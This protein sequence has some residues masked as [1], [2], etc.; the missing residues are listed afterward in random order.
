MAKGM[1]RMAPYALERCHTCGGTYDK[2]WA[3]KFG[4]KQIGDV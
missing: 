3:P 2:I 1:W 4:S